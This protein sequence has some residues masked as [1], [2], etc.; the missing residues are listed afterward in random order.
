MAQSSLF[1]RVVAT[2]FGGAEDASASPA[3]QQLIA[4]TI[5]MIVETVEPR[6]RMHARYREKLQGP[7]RCTIEYLR[8]LGKQPLEPIL[9]T[10]KAWADDPRVNAFFARADDVPGCLGRSR[11]LRAFFEDPVNKDIEEAFAL[12]GMKKDERSVFAPQLEGDVLKHDVAQVAV[13]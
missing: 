9:L 2:L 13:I 3:E 1:E 11:E 12:L 10:R 5:E 4:E 7:V 8:T 6:V